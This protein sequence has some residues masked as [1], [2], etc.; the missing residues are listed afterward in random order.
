MYFV[1]DL[2][3]NSKKK[4]LWLNTPFSIFSKIKNEVVDGG[5]R[6]VQPGTRHE[7]K[8]SVTHLVV[9]ASSA[10]PMQ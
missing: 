8:V 10:F 4:E 9:K 5:R 2:R 6:H 7:F 1:L 3:D